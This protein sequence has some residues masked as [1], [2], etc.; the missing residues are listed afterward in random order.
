MG[1]LNVQS[2]RREIRIKCGEKNPLGPRG[3]CE[4]KS[5]RNQA[6]NAPR[7]HSQPA[8]VFLLHAQHKLG[9][10]SA[11]YSYKGMGK[12]S[13]KMNNLEGRGWR[14]QRRVETE[15]RKGGWE[16]H[17]D[18]RKTR[19]EIKGGRTKRRERERIKL[20][21]NERGEERAKISIQ[22]APAG[23]TDGQQ[24]PAWSHMSTLETRGLSH[25]AQ[26]VEPETDETQTAA[27][28][29]QHISLHYCRR[30]TFRLMHR[31]IPSAWLS[32]I[33]TATPPSTRIKSQP[34]SSS[35]QTQNKIPQ[36]ERFWLALSC[37]LA[38]SPKNNTISTGDRDVKNKYT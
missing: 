4:A 3:L 24:F 2:N 26:T 5:A 18:I 13:F 32:S 35:D 29:P 28:W 33:L 34:P 11:T 21:K 22:G 7:V 6:E 9:R 15:W 30:C 23:Q 31:A 25:C 16:G 14:G 12:K 36:S 17:P 38:H 27:V 20:W 37:C 1:R 10:L 8:F 19:E